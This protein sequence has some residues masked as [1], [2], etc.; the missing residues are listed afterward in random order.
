MVRRALAGRT[1]LRVA[2]RAVDAVTFLLLLLLQLLLARMM[3]ALLLLRRRKLAP[4]HVV[5]FALAVNSGD[6]A[7]VDVGLRLRHVKRLNTIEIDQ[8]YCT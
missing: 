2:A 3:A 7:V 1:E 4:E 6:V 5:C 8:C